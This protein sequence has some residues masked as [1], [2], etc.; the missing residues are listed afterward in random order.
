M[1]TYKYSEAGDTC[2]L[3]KR[4]AICTL[5]DNNNRKY[6]RCKYCV[7][8]LITCVAEQIL[9]QQPTTFLEQYSIQ[10]KRSNNEKLFFIK[11]PLPGSNELVHCEFR[12]R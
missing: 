5:Q 4:S 10:A 9:V 7:E 6:V 3:C 2:P 11:S 12:K 8:F 1:L